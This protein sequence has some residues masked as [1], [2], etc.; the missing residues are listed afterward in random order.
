MEYSIEQTINRVKF[1]R[2]AANVR[3]CH[4][5]QAI[6]EYVIG[7]HSFN[8]LAMLRLLYPDAPKNLIWAI[9]EHDLPERLTGDIPSPAKWFGIIDRVQLQNLEW[10]ILNGIGLNPHDVHL[11]KEE[12]GWLKGLD[13]LELY[14][15]TMDQNEIGNSTQ[16]SMRNRIEMFMDQNISDYPVEIIDL[17]NEC[18]I[19]PWLTVPELGDVTE[20]W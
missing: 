1:M 19:G 18:K 16:E 4:T 10:M 8:M 3:R 2:E 11:T 5:T 17:Y 13:I 9:V 15:W 14:M 7:H 12:W 6:G 20:G